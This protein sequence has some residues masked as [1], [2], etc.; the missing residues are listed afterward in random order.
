MTR[1]VGQGLMLIDAN[2]TCNANYGYQAAG[3]ENQMPSCALNV[4]GK[5]I[6]AV[7]NRVSLINCLHQRPFVCTF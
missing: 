5:R 3:S 1:Y 7:K 2:N 6:V 4:S